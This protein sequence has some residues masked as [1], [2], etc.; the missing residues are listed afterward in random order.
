MLSLMELWFDCVSFG[1]YF[2]LYVKMEQRTE[3]L[4][5]LRACKI[6]ERGGIWKRMAGII[7]LSR[8]NKCPDFS[9]IS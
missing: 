6:S 9:S 4:D 7:L 1:V 5:V 2:K 3:S 8:L